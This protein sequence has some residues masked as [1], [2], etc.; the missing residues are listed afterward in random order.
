[1]KRIGILLDSSKCHPALYEAVRALAQSGQAELILLRA[2]RVGSARVPPLFGWLTQLEF[3]LLGRIYARVRRHAQRLDL[4]EWMSRAVV[5]LSPNDIEALRPLNLDL[6]LCDDAEAFD[7]RLAGAARDGLLSFQALAPFWQVYRRADSSAFEIQLR[8]GASERVLLRGHVP[9]RRSFSETLVTLYE[10]GFPWLARLAA[11]YA[12]GQPFPAAQDA[13][14]GPTR[15]PNPA[16]LF[17]YA[18]R[19]SWILLVY[20][21]ERKVLKRFKRWSVA[22]APGD[23][24]SADRSRGTPIQNLPGRYFAD[25]FL[26]A[27]DGRTVCFVE[28]FSFAQKRGRISAVEMLDDKN[29]KFLGPVIEEP[30]HM[31]FPYVF[32]YHRDLYMIPETSA[33]DS[34]RLY[35][36]RE[37]P[38]KWDFQKEILRGVRADDSMMFEH[39][40]RWWLLTNI[41][42]AGSA[43]F[44]SQLFAFHA[45]H[46]LA[47]E[48]TPHA[49]NPLVFDSRVARNGGLLRLA[50]GTLVRA[51]Q[52][53]AFNLYG[54]RL[55]LARILQ[56]TPDSYREEQIC[57]LEPDF[58]PGVQ[59][60]HHLFSNGRYTVYDF[61]RTEG[62]K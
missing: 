43:D 24:A 34:I 36:C 7:A 50:D 2:P 62:L 58:F 53:H 9:T 45:A 55:T 59:G 1:M 29:Y 5:E 51:R 12:A 10:T 32:E 40:G 14:R 41:A 25:P 52:G 11:Q 54:A 23:W 15:R 48:W 26:A 35:K 42:S 57:T 39:G 47:E 31:S 20:F 13:A 3:N 49:R 27:R 60:C 19:T 61:V 4:A 17:A 44:S 46:P 18:A 22:F 33:A 8:A 30:F 56:L 37:F 16:Q 21:V 6:I 28:D 38:M